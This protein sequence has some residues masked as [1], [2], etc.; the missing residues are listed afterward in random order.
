MADKPARQFRVGLGLFNLRRIGRHNCVDSGFNRARIRNLFHA[1]AFN[2]LG[3]I[4]A[5]GIDDFKQILGDFTADFIARDQRD[6][7]G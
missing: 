1:A 5:F 2:D 7:A 6:N 3:R 4:A